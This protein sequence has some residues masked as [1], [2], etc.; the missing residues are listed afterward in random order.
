MPV[1]LRQISSGS[2]DDRGYSDENTIARLLLEKPEQIT[3]T[4]TYTY[5]M[6]D[7]RFPLTFLTE[8]QGETGVKDIKTV[9]WTWKTMGRGKYNSKLVKAPSGDMIG[10]GGALVELEFEDHWLIEQYGVMAPD[11]MTHARIMKD[12]GESANGFKYLVKL[13]SP[14]PNAYFDPSNLEVGKYW[15]MTAPTITESY[16]KG[17]R[18]NVVGPGEMTGQLEFHRYSKEI[19]GELANRVVEY[20]FQNKSGGTTNLW[21]NEEMRQFDITRRIMEEERLWIAEYNRSSDGQVHFFD[22]DNGKPL[23][24]TSGMLE[25][26]R[27]SN[28]DTYGER[29]TVS[30]INRTI[31]DVLDKDTDT[32][33]ME[34]TLF[35]G[36]GFFQDFNDAIKDE[37]R[38]NGYVDAL[39]MKEIEDYEGGLSYGKFFKRLKTV[40]GHIITLKHLNFFDYGTM[41]ETAKM[42]GLVHPKSGLPLMSHQAIMVDM[43][44]YNGER[45]VKK[46]RHKDN[47]Y[48]QG[49]IKGLASIPASWGGVPTNILSQEVDASRYEIKTSA[50]LQV[51]NNK[52]MFLLKCEI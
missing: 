22:L 26:A 2:F 39:G 31:C 49:V 11:G 33:T 52:R 43:S 12:L 20:Q 45:N 38:S 4:L 17:N 36:K 10:L 14:D 40:D 41:A 27:E 8:G 23:Y 42:N 7:D 48:N 19:G 1:K 24:S 50:G 32:G 16:S 15:S 37:A 13:T 47:I 46:V 25:I 3:S 29:L 28:F 18:S 35:C 21:I 30:K 5:G 9:Q 6:D 51:N 44:M 34:V